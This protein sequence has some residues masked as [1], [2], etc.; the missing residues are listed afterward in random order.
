MERQEILYSHFP[1]DVSTPHLMIIPPCCIFLLDILTNLKHHC[2][3]SDSTRSGLKQ[4]AAYLNARITKVFYDRRPFT[5]LKNHLRVRLSDK[6]E[7]CFSRCT[8]GHTIFCFYRHHN[9]P[10]STKAF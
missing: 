7:V 9:G 10:P 8:G 3:N 6:Q 1:K 5:N 2:H 4:P